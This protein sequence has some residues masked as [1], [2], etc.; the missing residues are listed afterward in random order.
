MS[1][2]STSRDTFYATLT[3]GEA[4]KELPLLRVAQWCESDLP[5][6]KQPNMYSALKSQSS[7]GIRT[8]VSCDLN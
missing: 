1:S 3:V 2:C 6:E 7:G 5:D 4:T 8:L